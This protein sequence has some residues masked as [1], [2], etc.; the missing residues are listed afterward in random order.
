M[1]NSIEFDRELAL[2]RTELY[3]NI[4]QY[5]SD[6][7][8]LEVEVP[9]LG[10][11]AALDPHVQSLRLLQDEHDLFLQ[12]SPEFFMKRLICQGSGDIFTI[13]KSFRGDEQGRL[14]NP[15]FSMLEWYRLDFS[16]GDLIE[17]VIGLLSKLGVDAPRTQINYQ[18]AFFEATG[19]DPHQP[20][21]D[22][23]HGLASEH[24]LQVTASSQSSEMIDFLMSVA[25]EPSLPS[26]LV[27]LKN[28]P[29]DQAE[30]AVIQRD[31]AGYDIAQRFEIYLERIEIA[32]GYQ[33]LTDGKEQR[34]R[35]LDNAEARQALELEAVSL[36]EK[37]LAAVDAGMPNCAGVALGLDR[38]LMILCG[39]PK[40]AET[41]CFP[42]EDL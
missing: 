32:N 2:A 37:F 18:D 21:L 28:F 6:Q 16:M 26:G 38:L 34:R 23:L 35:F 29:A 17:D 36:D 8:V 39:R 14:H 12:T 11:G 24:G 5:F 3:Q 31:E 27:V 15:E 9:L 19:I 7:A 40:L 1:T 22:R 42:F 25:V 41:L 33:E 4:R 20:D 13:C 30:L 10:R